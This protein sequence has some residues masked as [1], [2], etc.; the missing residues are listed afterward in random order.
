VVEVG[1]ADEDMSGSMQLVVE[2]VVR[3]VGEA[4]V[5]IEAGVLAGCYWRCS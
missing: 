5:K 4:V 1:F 2:A 3:G